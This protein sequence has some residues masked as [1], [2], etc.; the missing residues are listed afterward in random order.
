MFA[1]EALQLINICLVA[2][3]NNFLHV[4]CLKLFIQLSIARVA[5]CPVSQAT[6]FFLWMANYLHNRKM[7]D[8]QQT[9]HFL[10]GFFWSN[11]HLC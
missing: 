2:E 8:E 11:D 10:K 3:R 9:V 5:L 7:N 1:L 6:Y 4:T